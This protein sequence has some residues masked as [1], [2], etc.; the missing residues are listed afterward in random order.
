MQSSRSIREA[1]DGHRQTPTRQDECTRS[2]PGCH[3]KEEAS[4]ETDCSPELANKETGQRTSEE[5]GMMSTGDYIITFLFFALILAGILEMVT[6][7]DSE[8]VRQFVEMVKR[9]LGVK[10]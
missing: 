5:A 9:Y 8:E 1:I 10:S 6:G 4:R 2:D 3:P 7:G